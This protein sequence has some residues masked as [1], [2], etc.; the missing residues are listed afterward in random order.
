MKNKLKKSIG[1]LLAIV[2]LLSVFPIPAGAV[3][4]V[5]SEQVFDIEPEVVVIDEA[6]V[7][8]VVIDDLPVIEDDAFII[9]ADSSIWDRAVEPFYT[10]FVPFFDPIAA[11]NQTIGNEQFTA[12]IGDLG[13]I[14][15][16]RM[17]NNR[18]TY[19][20]IGGTAAGSTQPAATLDP[21]PNFLIGN[22]SSR[23]ASTAHQWTGGLIFATRSAATEAELRASTAAFREQD[24]NKT[25]ANGGS[26]TTNT[27]AAGNPRISRAGEDLGLT[28]KGVVEITYKGLDVAPDAG[29]AGTGSPGPTGAA[30]NDARIMRGYDVVSTY[31]MDTEDGSLLWTIE[32]KN[33]SEQW[34]EF[35]DIG[36]PMSWNN[37]YNGNSQT[38][39]YS[40]RV[41]ANAFAG[42]DSGYAH[43]KRASG[44][45]NSLIFA[46]VPGSGARI[47]YVD[48]WF[49]NFQG[50]RGERHDEMF[51]AWAHD[52]A[53]WSTGMAV[54]YIHSKNIR[55][56]GA[57]YHMDNT[58]LILG[59]GQS[60]SYQFKFMP[61][62]AT[63]GNVPD[64]PTTAADLTNPI[65]DI[66]KRAL[67][68]EA[69]LRS[70]LYNSG[71]V[72]IVALPG[73]QTAINMPTKMN[74]HFDKGIIR[75][76]VPRILCVHQE[77]C[78]HDCT[79]IPGH[80]CIP[81][82]NS[83]ASSA[84]VIVSN[85]AA[86]LPAMAAS[87]H[88]HGRDCNYNDPYAGTH[89][90]VLINTTGSVTNGNYRP[91]AFRERGYMGVHKYF[92]G[93]NGKA[94]HNAGITV[95]KDQAGADANG[96]FLNDRD[97]WNQVWDLTFG[98][99]GN[100]SVRVD[101]ELLVGLDD[102][103]KEIWEKKFT[104]V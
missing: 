23:E 56:T 85:V 24:T 11:G 52:S 69:N 47:E 53:S 82:N 44:E 35:G 17:K 46:P 80:V 94:L 78:L 25:L 16:L 68:A 32:I 5:D 87:G 4:E 103:G 21:D 93:L 6:E 48:Q 66:Q 90:P 27:I 49:R 20:E 101:Y 57:G 12:V 28:G 92:D 31:D 60:E 74:L 34:I 70:N 81:T 38:V 91:T 30:G 19:Q 7:A 26:T 64:A 51:Y 33:K 13:Q 95:N 62:R 41:V 43:I 77:E 72:D 84:S 29:T 73:F 54:Y 89:I 14:R 40:Q 37:Q 59:P 61:V 65:N 1:L 83:G 63:E 42:V 76:A 2:M 102:E 71:M 98:C 45:G 39:N 104:Q 36:M 22:T 67:T 86:C 55:S 10:G 50:I 15:E 79:R 96:F 88:V 97:E 99:I 58:S 9:A 100:N 75:N 3:Y 8:P 18:T